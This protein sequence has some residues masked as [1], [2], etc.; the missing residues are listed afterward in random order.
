MYMEERRSGGLVVSGAS[1][2]ALVAIL[3]VLFLKGVLG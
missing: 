2:G 3:I 1:A